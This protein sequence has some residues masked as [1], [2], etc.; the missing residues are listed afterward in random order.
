MRKAVN[1]CN[2]DYGTIFNGWQDVTVQYTLK[3]IVWWGGVLAFVALL[4]A[5]GYIWW[6]TETWEARQECFARAAA[7][8]IGQRNTAY[9]RA[10]F[11]IETHNQ[12]A[13]RYDV[14]GTASD[15]RQHLEGVREEIEAAHNSSTGR[16]LFGD[17]TPKVGSVSSPGAAPELLPIAEMGDPTVNAQ[18]ERVYV[19]GNVQYIA[20]EDHKR[21]VRALELKITTLRT[22]NNQ[23]KERLAAAGQ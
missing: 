15:E 6:I 11:A 8:L 7:V 14:L 20:Y 12:L 3:N 10:R 23:Y 13:D 22:S 2:R 16:T 17:Q 18:G 5:L 19:S 9:K 21:R 4:C 1:P